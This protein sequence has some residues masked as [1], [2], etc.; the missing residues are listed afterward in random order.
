MTKRHEAA[1]AIRNAI[2]T[3]W[4]RPGQIVSQREIM[5]DLKLSVTP[6][7][8]ALIELS[9]LGILDARKHT[10][11]RIASV[12][13]PRL[14]QV[15][16][17]RKQLETIAVAEATE[18][19]D[20]ATI[21]RLEELN[22]EIAFLGGTEQLSRINELDREFHHLVFAA[23][24]DEPRLA[25]IEF[26]RNAFAFYALWRDSA[27]VAASVKEHNAIL[28]ALDK[29]DA[30]AAAKAHGR[31]LDSGLKAALRTLKTKAMS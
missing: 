25:S 27:R 23:A 19:I 1:A 18:H 13:A 11:I 12:D 28:R 17:L 5:A 2:E 16:R 14:K 22:A 10:N 31:H 30:D 21:R 20:K 24:Q 8:E 26:T 6:T 4:Y 3:G 29:R 15:Y 9:A 7:R